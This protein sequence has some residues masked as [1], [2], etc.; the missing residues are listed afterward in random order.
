MTPTPPAPQQAE[1][2]TF[3]M[4]KVPEPSFWFMRDNHTFRRLA[5]NAEE[6]SAQC[7]EEFDAGWTYGGLFAKNLPSK[8]FAVHASGSANRED[9]R[10]NALAALSASRELAKQEAKS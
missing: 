10:I 5:G 7:M 3:G 4:E 6:M 9:F 1:A 8:S 2:F